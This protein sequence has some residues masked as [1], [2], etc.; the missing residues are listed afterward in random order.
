MLENTPRTQKSKPRVVC[1]S[2]HKAVNL[3]ESSF[4]YFSKGVA[5]YL[6]PGL[7]WKTKEGHLC[8][9]A[10]YIVKYYT[11]ANKYKVVILSKCSDVQSLHKQDFTSG[12]L[13]YFRINTILNWSSASKASC[14]PQQLAYSNS[15]SL[16]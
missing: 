2:Y 9:S 5:F 6:P 16:N 3:T 12:R 4:T 11:N 14:M 7:A 10:L 15:A 8:G 13:N 1:A